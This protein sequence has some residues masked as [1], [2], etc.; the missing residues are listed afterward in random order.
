MLTKEEAESCA[1]PEISRKKEKQQKN[2][3][4]N[5]VD[6]ETICTV[7]EDD[8]ED[9]GSVFEGREQVHDDAALNDNVD[10]GKTFILELD[11]GDE[12]IHDDFNHDTSVDTDI[13]LPCKKKPKLVSYQDD[14]FELQLKYNE[15][16]LKTENFRKTAA[17]W[18]S[19]HN[20]TAQIQVH[21]SEAPRHSR[22]D[23]IDRLMNDMIISEEQFVSLKQKRF[24]SHKNFRRH[25][26]EKMW[27]D[28][29][30]FL[31][32]SVNS[33]W[34]GLLIIFIRRC[35]HLQMSC[36]TWTWQVDSYPLRA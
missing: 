31:C 1:P 5:S 13:S 26:A 30:D 27:H 6:D 24:I 22:V 36:M 29:R 12:D 18:K 32:H 9:N 16:L 3:N 35:T 21:A 33:L 25:V 2:K 34:N 15:L 10:D 28:K 7:D 20:Q 23:I 4:S 11:S 14:L 8:V 17:Y 19:R